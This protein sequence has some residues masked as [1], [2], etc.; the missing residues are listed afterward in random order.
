MIY[1]SINLIIYPKESLKLFRNVEKYELLRNTSAMEEDRAN[2]HYTKVS[3]KSNISRRMLITTNCRLQRSLDVLGL[4]CDETNSIFRVIAVVLKLGNFIFVPVTNID[5]TE[6]CQVS[7]V[8]G[9]FHHFDDINKYLMFYNNF[10]I[11]R[12][13]RDGAAAQF[14]SSN[15]NQ[16][17]DKSEQYEQYTGGCGL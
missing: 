12:G 13:S 3:Q 7:N 11:C 2:F 1:Y 15:I 16:L 4:N 8:Y 5:G 6:G 17:S 10:V 14:G 9:T